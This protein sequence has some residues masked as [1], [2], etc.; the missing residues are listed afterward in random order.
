M[1]EL[2]T[3]IILN[4]PKEQIWK[5]LTDFQNYPSWNPFIVSIEGKPLLHSQLKNTLM[6]KGKP[7][8][9]TPTVT[10]LEENRIFEWLGS[11]LL[12]TFKG[13]HY[14]ILEDIGNGQ[15]KLIHG[16]KFSGL[17][18]GPILKM[19]GDETLLNFQRMNKALKERVEQQLAV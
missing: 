15:T 13:R 3:E 12:G 19:I 7:M 17:L 1:K 2:K 8:V 6:S 4:A 9:F 5:V 14:F 11:G 18:S 16:E 10:R